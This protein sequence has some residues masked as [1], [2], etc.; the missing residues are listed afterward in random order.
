MVY[1]AIVAVFGPLGMVAGG[2]LADRMAERGHNDSNLRVGPI[3]ALALIASGL[4]Y[5]IVSS[6]NVAAALLVPTVFLTSAPLGVAPAAI[7]QMMPNPLRS[8]ASAVY[9]FVINLIGLGSG[10]TA[11]ALTTDYVFRDDNAVRHSLLVVAAASNVV[12][13]FLLWRGMRHY[14]RGLEKLQEWG[15]PQTN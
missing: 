11:V 7:Q 2:R 15:R 8:L 13:G 3:A 9:L 14:R 5:P 4:L 10:P 12:S 1:G 6:A